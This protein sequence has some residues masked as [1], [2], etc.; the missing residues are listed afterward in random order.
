ME[1]AVYGESTEVHSAKPS[2]KSFKWSSK[3]TEN[4]LRKSNSS[5]RF[6]G[7][8]LTNLPTDCLSTCLLTMKDSMTENQ[9]DAITNVLI[10][11]VFKRGDNIVNE[12]DSASS[13]Y[14]IK[15][16]KVGIF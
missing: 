3:K 5:V 10:T 16:G 12:G 8:I 4:S 11:Q 15:K 6:S 14:I 13:Y 2:K 9:K 1:S 7:Y